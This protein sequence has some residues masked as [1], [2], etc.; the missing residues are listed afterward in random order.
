MMK[1]NPGRV[2]LPKI[3][4]THNETLKMLGSVK[5]REACNVKSRC[6]AML[7]SKGLSICT[8]SAKNSRAANL[9][10]DFRRC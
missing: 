4:L 5:T 9:H 8:R 1:H 7:N 2:I 3:I 10:A 6:R